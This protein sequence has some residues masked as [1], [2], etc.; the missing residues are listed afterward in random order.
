MVDIAKLV[1]LIFIFPFCL[2]I[3][4]YLISRKSN[5]P[6]V[7]RMVNFISL[8]IFIIFL[9]SLVFYIFEFEAIVYVIF[10][11]ALVVAAVW[12]RKGLS[13]FLGSQPIKSVVTCYGIF[14]LWVFLLSTFIK[15]YSGGGWFGDWDEHYQRT[16]FFKDLYPL[17]TIFT[18]GWLLTARPPLYNVVASFFL[19][20]LGNQ[21]YYYQATSVFLNTLVF[22]G[23][24]AAFAVYRKERGSDFS[25]GLPVL[26][27]FLALNPSVLVNVTY[28]WTRALTNFFV[29]YSLTLFYLSARNNDHLLR[30][31]SYFNIGV[32]VLTHY[33]AVPYLVGLMLLDVYFVARG[34]LTVKSALVNVG[35]FLAVISPWFL[36]ALYHYGPSITFGSNSTVL[37]SS[38]LGTWENLLK[39]WNNIISTFIPHFLRKV[40]DLYRQKYL[41]GHIR[42][43]AFLVYQVNFL[44]MIGSVG[45]LIVLIS[46]V[47]GSALT[48]MSGEREKLLLLW[49]FFLLVILVGVAVHGSY[50][51][52]GVGHICLQPLAIL[53]IVYLAANFKG[54]NKYVK[55]FLCGGLFIDLLFGVLL[56]FWMQHYSF[57]DFVEINRYGL[58]FGEN[59][60]S[61]IIYKAKKGYVFI[62]DLSFSTSITVLIMTILIALLIYLVR[63]H[64]DRNETK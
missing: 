23:A 13:D 54:Y 9:V 40:P 64:Q 27:L 37:D 46:S 18:G 10:S 32:A 30:R 6:D 14:V 24:Y 31:L 53:C 42:D 39:I 56:H 3:P 58:V 41:L 2:F 8:S 33:S 5:L 45:W 57:N 63:C 26:V 51:P 21:F 43:Y 4:G 19:N 47:K 7:I 52:F 49:S 34:R 11:L 60:T 55:A 1:Y 61:D 44:F 12:K 50:D 48:L 59:I 36:F 22:F 35:I 62:A 20:H 38:G 29:L 16:L 28:S 15:H 17:D 25:A